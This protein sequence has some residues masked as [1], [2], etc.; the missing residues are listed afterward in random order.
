MSTVVQA[1]R[2]WRHMSVK[3]ITWALLLIM[4]LLT[5]A[6]VVSAAPPPNRPQCNKALTIA[7]TQSLQF[8]DILAAGSGTVTISPTGA[9][10]STGGA[11]A[12]GGVS[13]PAIFGASTL[14]GCASLGHS[15]LLPASINLTSGGNTMT[16][17]T[18]ASALSVPTLV[19]AAGAGQVGVG[20]TLHVGNQQ[21]AG[22]YSGQFLIEIVFQ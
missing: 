19:D 17:D 18:F 5:A 6:G 21:A 22:N 10:S 16:V 3:R 15:L 2:Y 4:T 14:A 13:S 1:I 8:G 7:N 20:A 9:R 12:A 11:I